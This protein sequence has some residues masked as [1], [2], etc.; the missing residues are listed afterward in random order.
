MIKLVGVSGAQGA[1]KSTLLEGLKAKGWAVDSFKVSRAVQKKLGWDSLERVMDDVHTMQRFQE[2]VLHQ[3]LLRDFDMG[4]LETSGVVLTER[5]F[6]DIAAYTTYWCWEH[7]DR[8]NWTFS[9]ATA[10]LSPYLQRCLTAQLE[11]YGAVVLLP[12]MSVVRWQEDPNRAGAA[13]RDG[14]YEDIERFCDKQLFIKK[15]IITAEG[16]DDRV[17]QAHNFLTAL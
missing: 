3:K 15:L 7:V 13:S 17:Q 9:E 14:I 2:E 10:W 11:C 4:R 5:T 1:G 16:V 6:A 12:Y 8:R